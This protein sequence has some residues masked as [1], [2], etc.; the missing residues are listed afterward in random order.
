MAGCPSLPPRPPRGDRNERLTPTGFRRTPVPPPTAHVRR[1]LNRLAWIDRPTGRVIRRYERANTGELIHRH[2]KKV[3]KIPPG[4]VGGSTRRRRWR[5]GN[6]RD[7]CRPLPYRASA[8]VAFP[9][10]HGRSPAQKPRK[11]PSPAGTAPRAAMMAST[12]CFLRPRR[13]ERRCSTGGPCGEDARP[14]VAETGLEPASWRTVARAPSFVGTDS[15]GI[16]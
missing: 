1:G 11:T 10:L 9:L 16:K 4:V 13:G 3:G 14:Q 5:E 6:H 2:T 7:V 15:W 12:S 8:A